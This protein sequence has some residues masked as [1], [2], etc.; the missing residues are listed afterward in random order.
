MNGQACS[1]METEVR[2]SKKEFRES[3]V[4][5]IH[6]TGAALSSL[7]QLFQSTEP[8]KSPFSFLISWSPPSPLLPPLMQY[9][10]FPHLARV[11]HSDLV[12]VVQKGNH[13]PCDFLHCIPDIAYFCVII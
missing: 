1:D 8:K 10:P 11:L 12:V 9:S 3:E 5:L 4:V 13:L 6:N 2:E 7:G